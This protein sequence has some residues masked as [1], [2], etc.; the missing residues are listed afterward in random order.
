MHL[1]VFVRML[2]TRRNGLR[3]QTPTC[4]F[5]C[6]C[7]LLVFGLLV[8][9]VVDIWSYWNLVYW[10][11]AL[12]VFGLIGLWSHWEDFSKNISFMVYAALRGQFLKKRKPAKPMMSLFFN[13]L[14]SHSDT[15]FRIYVKSWLDWYQGHFLKRFLRRAVAHQS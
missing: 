4:S 14:L 6:A 1:F 5:S 3:V 13:C 10:Y 15:G 12:F 2:S 9:G 11:L 8:L 7:C